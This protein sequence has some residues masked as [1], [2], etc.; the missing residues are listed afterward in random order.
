MDLKRKGLSV[1]AIARQLGLDRKTVRR[2]QERGLNGHR[3]GAFELAQGR[4]PMRFQGRG[5]GG[6]ASCGRSSSAAALRFG[7]ISTPDFLPLVAAWPVLL[8][9]C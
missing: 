5:V 4:C 8:T 1:S 9:Y 3:C 2:H 7:V 6:G